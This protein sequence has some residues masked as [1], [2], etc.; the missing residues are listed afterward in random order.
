MDNEPILNNSRLLTKFNNINKKL[1]VIYSK[2][3]QR[4][5][6]LLEKIHHLEE[7]SNKKNFIREPAKIKVVQNNKIKVVK[8][9]S[10]INK[11]KKVVKVPTQVPD[12]VPTQV[13]TQL[14][15]QVPK[16]VPTQLTTQVP[17][18]VP[19]Q[20]T[21]QVP[22]QVPTQYNFIESRNKKKNVDQVKTNSNI[23]IEKNNKTNNRYT[24]ETDINYNDYIQK[25]R[26]L[27]TEPIFDILIPKKN[28]RVYMNFDKKKIDKINIGDIFK[29]QN[30]KRK[31]KTI[32][33]ITES[34]LKF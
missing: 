27:K 25:K 7:E 11:N 1:N 16:Q 19:T 10:Q 23:N 18:Q 32:F 24:Y 2:Y 5:Q 3:N 12:Q 6:K 28:N 29:I 31:K 15:T 17:K 22:K 13:P 21:T 4:I 26:Y 8:E 33:D 20:L 14:T 30:R 9:P 34:D